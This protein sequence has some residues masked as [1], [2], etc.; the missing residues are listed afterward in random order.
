MSFKNIL[1]NF[2]IWLRFQIYHLQYFFLRKERE[3]LHIAGSEETV[4]YI[5][6]HRCSVTRFGD[7]EIELITCLLEGYDDSRK[8]AFQKYDEVLATR[9]KEIL[10]QGFYP[11]R[12]L[13]VCLPA[14]MI[15]PVGVKPKV[16]TFWKRCFVNNLATLKASVD[17]SSNYYDTN[18]T[19][20]YIDYLNKDKAEY[21]THIRK[22]WDGRELCIIEG[23]QSRLGVG[24]DLFSNA[25]SIERILCPAVSAFSKYS[26]ILESA[27]KVSKDKLVLLAIGQTATVLAYDMSQYGY[28]VIDVGHVDLEYEWF[29]MQAEDKVALPKKYVNEVVD[30]RIYTEESDSA[31]LSQIIDRI[32]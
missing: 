20:F 31:Y 18:F 24:N 12:N 32:I 21:V 13:I 7:G 1:L 2:K 5:L 25:K 28:Q 6:K 22:I 29:L 8:S 3:K 10:K 11:E 19:R 26:S 23:E 4:N 15:N 27:L 9:L 14:I 30:G 16:N 17:F